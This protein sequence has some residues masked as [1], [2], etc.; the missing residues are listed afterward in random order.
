MFKNQGIM[1]CFSFEEGKGKSKNQWILKDLFDLGRKFLPILITVLSLSL[2][3]AQVIVTLGDDIA[4]CENDNVI[5]D[6]LNPFVSGA[7]G[8]KWWETSGDGVF[9]DTFSYPGAV[10]YTP[11]VADLANG[12]VTITLKARE[13]DPNGTVYE[14]NAIVYFRG[15][16]LFACNDNITIPLNFHCEYL[17]T[18]PMLL[19]GEDEN[20]PY[21][22][23][24]IEIYDENGD[25]VPNNNVTGDYIGQTLSY[26]ITHECSWNAC[27]GT[28]N[29]RD[30]YHPVTNCENDTI[31]CQNS[32]DPFDLGF[33]IDT[34]IFDLD[35]IFKIDTQKY[36]VQGWD[37]CGDVVL[38]YIDSTFL[39]DCNQDSVFQQVTVRYWKAVDESN[40]ISRCFDS[41]FVKRIS[42]DSVIL[43]PN[44]NNQDS[45]A[46]QCNGDWQLTA[47]P[48]GN[49]S[50]EY[51]GAPEIWWCN[52]LEYSFSDTRYGGCGNTFDVTRDWTL[53]DWCTNEIVHY[54]QMIKIMDTEP[55]HMVCNDALVTVGSDPYDCYSASYQ[56]DIP[57]VYDECS[58]YTLF[59]HVYNE[60]NVEVD[61]QNYGGSFF[62][63]QLPLGLYSVQF[64]AVDECSN[65]SKC[66]YD[67][68]VVD[69][70]RPYAICDQHT[71]INLGTNGEA[72]LFPENV[73]DGSFDNCEIVDW[74][75]RKMT[76]DCDSAYF[77]FGP[78]VGFCCD[79]SG[80]TL[81]VAMQVTDASGNSNTCMVEV[82]VEDKLPPQII[83][84][85]DIT[86]SCDYYFDPDDL[87]RYFGKVVTDQS[88]RED[89]VIHDVYND[90]VV[91]KDGYAYDN[92]DVT[93]DQSIEFDIN[94]CNI[95]KIF[96]TF[97]AI[98][99]GGR[100]NPCL[101]T[102]TI[103]NPEPFNYYGDDIIWPKDTVFYG[104]S[105]LEADTSITGA[106][107]VNDNT[108]SMV[109]LLYEDQ[110]FSVEDDACEKI[111]RK[112]TVRDWC[113]PNELYWTYDQIIMLN[114]IIAPTF[115]SDCFDRD[116]C[117]YG[118]C[119][120]LVELSAS[121]EDDCTAQEELVWR[122]KLD[123]DNDG[124]YD[125]FGQGNHF[126]QTMEIGTYEIAWVV[127]DKCG[128]QSHCNY[129]FTVKDC[130]N[131]TPYCISDLT[132]V[133]MNQV[134]MVTVK[135]IDFDHGS[136][137]NCTLSNYGTCGC[138]TDLLFS[139]SQDV[140]DT[141]YNITCDSLV[142]GVA[143]TFY[144]KMWVTDEAGNQD[145]CL[146]QLQVQDNNGVCPDSDGME[147]SGTLNKWK[148][149]A[150]V[151]GINIK[152]RN[153][154]LEENKYD[155]SGS[156]GRY[157]FSNISSGD[158]Y[159]VEP[160]DD[161]ATCLS[162]VSTADV[163]KIQKHI[164]GIKNFDSPY[165]YLA[166]D[167]NQS[168]SISAADILAIR[169][170]ILGAYDAFPNNKCW[171]YVDAKQQLSINNPYNYKSKLI[172][173]DM[174][175]SVND[176]DFK[177]VK[178]GDINDNHIPQQMP[179]G[180]E[181]RNA[182]YA[183]IELG[184]VDYQSGN[185]VK[186]PVYI[187]SNS[188]IEGMQFTINFPQDILRYETMENGQIDINEYN[189]GLNYL[190]EGK[191]S[192]SWNTS[193]NIEL[194]YNQPAFYM[195]F[196]AKNTGNVSRDIRISSD[197]TAA[198]SVIDDNEAGLRVLYRNSDSNTEFAVYQNTPN[199]F[200][201]ET[202]VKFNLPEKGMVELSVYDITGKQVYKLSKE[203]DK[204]L[205]QL[206]IKH[207][208]VKSK[209]IF[210]YTLKTKDNTATK[211][212]ILIE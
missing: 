101:Q 84:P 71:K 57:E 77:E 126:S 136:Y 175:S 168:K 21:N 39:Y 60:D 7:N 55:P 121:A 135:A 9:N 86:V 184:D 161:K 5:L 159:D 177:V 203:F 167:A 190:K 193:E 172:F 207:S 68:E 48:N 44:W 151:K 148:D 115:T 78:Y 67:L 119:E 128:N 171:L 140:T 160:Q 42:L 113:Q 90:G 16:E 108:C 10:S 17:V 80:D 38:S 87:D 59:V 195:I 124:V 29:V 196:D 47:L 201:N 31:T 51:T 179:G 19:E 157:E 66:S 166:A 94:N 112:W 152:M 131:P 158:S 142:N 40:N 37:A 122:W 81:M 74:Q 45:A 202:T 145:Y 143:R 104:C 194:D 146:I 187:K 199:P 149:N 98:D 41:I 69:D 123:S 186:V 54:T 63:S 13:S 106:P 105:N 58:S 154:T 70:Q 211:K 188:G 141:I 163:V 144:L 165:Q 210:Y 102:I 89:I 204:G 110:I 156:N 61:V 35:T 176:A 173:T 3:N 209:G 22:L 120:G 153:S 24:N 52:S 117:V 197:I 164:L 111:I 138:E 178:V 49:P 109:A 11:G 95:G 181:F 183:V 116:V 43:P 134:G 137:D 97:T 79:E 32:M 127:E 30:N 6:D 185:T 96:R 23:Y 64:T 33:P 56:L 91:G 12:Q 18:P 147:L 50:P 65:I 212:M 100:T 46:L 150:P 76:Y 4:V 133:V 129:T 114:N 170:L 92:C 28:I 191:I 14:D 155:E 103:Y 2:T 53:V 192:F 26:N 20:V 182:D 85:P 132:T 36:I 99:N 88:L 180:L 118:E 73:D 174:I 162:G 75:I 198:L 27:G 15:D 25:I 83:C 205:S 72:R 208:D 8:S 169:K 1:K 107:I 130:K 200:K 93:I 82:L 206:I 34:F 125:E 189:T 139:F 62:I